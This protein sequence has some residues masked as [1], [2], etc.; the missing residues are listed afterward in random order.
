[1]TI[2]HQDLITLETVAQAGMRVRAS[3][4][5]SS[6]RRQPT[7]EKCRDE[8]REQRIQR[9]LNELPELDSATFLKRSE[10][11][12]SGR[13][14]SVES[15]ASEL[16]QADGNAS[17]GSRQ[18]ALA[19]RSP[20]FFHTNHYK[21]RCPTQVGW[22]FTTEARRPGEEEDP[23]GCGAVRGLRYRVIGCMVAEMRRAGI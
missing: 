16:A 18:A 11:R 20:G 5:G 1:M 8:A 6:F 15:P 17:A 19:D 3:A 14:E 23:E 9:T 10:D 13:R 21:W 22:N 2:I 12:A 7:L 4:G